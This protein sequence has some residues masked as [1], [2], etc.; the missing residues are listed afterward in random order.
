MVE[1]TQ[2]ARA[3]KLHNE[4]ENY[5]KNGRNYAR[6]KLVSAFS[7][8][9]TKVSSVEIS[10][11]EGIT[12]SAGD[13]LLTETSFPLFQTQHHVSKSWVRVLIIFVKNRWV[14]SPGDRCVL[15]C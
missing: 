2:A 5:T 3:A 14:D 12:I 1:F 7:K 15:I 11:S 8:R 6:E 9:L 13:F 10:I 4:R